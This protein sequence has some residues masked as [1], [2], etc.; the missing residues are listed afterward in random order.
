MNRSCLL[1]HFALLIGLQIALV[2]IAALVPHQMRATVLG[3]MYDHWLK[4]GEAMFPSGPGGHAMAG[5]AI[6]GFLFG[7]VIYAVVFAFVI[8]FARSRLSRSR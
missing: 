1:K 2:I 8:C 4:V 6:A 5:G 3:F 7:V